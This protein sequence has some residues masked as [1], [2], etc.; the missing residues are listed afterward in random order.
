MVV[1]P[2]E[3]RAYKLSLGLAVVSGVLLAGWTISAVIGATTGWG[4]LAYAGVGLIS[5]AIGGALA[6]ISLLVIARSRQ[7][8]RPIRHAVFALVAALVFAVAPL[9]ALLATCNNCLQ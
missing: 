8:G 5:P 4:E 3:P 2:G 7:V 9:A 6:F 1:D